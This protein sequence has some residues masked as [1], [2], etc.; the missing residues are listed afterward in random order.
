MLWITKKLITP[1]TPPGLIGTKTDRM[2]CARPPIPV[3]AHA[4]VGTSM[5]RRPAASKVRS[6]ASIAGSPMIS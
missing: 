1:G 6:K 4:T 3:G 2:T 5:D